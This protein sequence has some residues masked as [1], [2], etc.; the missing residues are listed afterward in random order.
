MECKCNI[1][2]FIKCLMEIN[3]SLDHHSTRINV[4]VTQSCMMNEKAVR[5]IRN[6]NA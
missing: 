2:L 6:E 1:Y 5:D 3:K 4:H